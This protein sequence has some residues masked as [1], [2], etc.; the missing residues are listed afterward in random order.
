MRPP[1]SARAKPRAVPA[2]LSGDDEL[3]GVAGRRRLELGVEDG[4]DDRPGQHRP[5]RDQHPDGD[6]AA[7]PADL[8]QARVVGQKA[9]AA[10]GVVGLLAAGEGGSRRRRVRRRRRGALGGV[11]GGGDDPTA[12]ARGRFVIVL[13]HLSLSTRFAPRSRRARIRR[14]RRRGRS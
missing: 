2:R 12:G 14:R 3:G 6:H 13:A 9:P 8:R 11:A 1:A 5:G 4:D 10:G 7:P